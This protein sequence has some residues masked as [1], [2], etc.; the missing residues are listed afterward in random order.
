MKKSFPFFRRLN[1]PVP[2]ERRRKYAVAELHCHLEATV[3]PE[4][5]R[6]IAMRN[7]VDISHTFD[8]DGNYEWRTFE[9]F[10]NVYDAVSEAIRKAEDYYEI[11]LHHYR[12]MAAKGMIYGEVFISPAH[13]MRFG[14]SYESLIDAVASGVASS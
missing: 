5:A 4:D 3:S 12:R 9:E 8:D 13:A 11:T 2:R 10:L 14:L 6:K 7:G 1:N